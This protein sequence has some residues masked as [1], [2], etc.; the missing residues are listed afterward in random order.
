MVLFLFAVAGVVSEAGPTAFVA[1]LLVGVTLF[2][3]TRERD[4]PR[5]LAA[6]ACFLILG[7][8]ASLTPTGPG[9]GLPLIESAK[10][11]TEPTPHVHGPCEQANDRR[12]LAGAVLIVGAAAALFTA[13]R[14]SA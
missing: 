1:A 6:F 13:R 8:G 5:L 12:G 2:A 11:S 10:H 3:T 4:V 9:C 7:L 14:R